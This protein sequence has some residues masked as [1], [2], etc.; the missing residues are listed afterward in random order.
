[1]RGTRSKQF[2]RNS[3]IGLTAAAGRLL[4]SKWKAEAIKVKSSIEQQEE[5]A[6]ISVFLFFFH[7]RGYLFF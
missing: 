5:G 2:R 4:K 6:S 1:M 7:L 3:H